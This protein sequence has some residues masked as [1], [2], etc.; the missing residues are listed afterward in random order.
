MEE[1]IAFTRRLPECL[2]AADVEHDFHV[3]GGPMEYAASFVSPPEAGEGAEPSFPLRFFPREPVCWAG[4]FGQ[5]RAA[6][7][8]VVAFRQ[9]PRG[10][11]A[12]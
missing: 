7:E 4:S 6:A 12:A 11:R 10:A 5:R 9:G 2:A 8:K 1:A 3:A